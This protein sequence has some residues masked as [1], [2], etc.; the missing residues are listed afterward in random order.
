MY[1][2]VVTIAL[3]RES[4][5]KL[6]NYATFTKARATA[7]EMKSVSINA[8]NQKKKKNGAP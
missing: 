3:E 6:S 7:K 4:K 2:T 1:R 8:G 5:E